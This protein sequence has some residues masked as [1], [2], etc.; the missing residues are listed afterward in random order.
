MAE[1]EPSDRIKSQR[2]ERDSREMMADLERACPV[3]AGALRRPLDAL[4]VSDRWTYLHIMREL[5][6]HA[7]HGLWSEVSDRPSRLYEMSEMAQVRLLGRALSGL[8]FCGVSTLL[9]KDCYGYLL[10]VAS[11]TKELGRDEESE[12][13]ATLARKMLQVAS[14]L[15]LENRQMRVVRTRHAGRGDD[16]SKHRPCIRPPGESARPMLRLVKK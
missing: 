5:V 15:Y 11:I 6:R 16:A 2:K 9:I 3:L 12:S 7:P 13:H 14:L 10:E 1:D 4:H 8:T